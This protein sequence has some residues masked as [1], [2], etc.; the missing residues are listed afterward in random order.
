VTH[1]SASPLVQIRPG[2]F[3]LKSSTT[4][5]SAVADVPDVVDGAVCRVCEGPTPARFAVCYCCEVLVRQLQIPLVPIV[6]VTNY[7]IGDEMHRRLRGYKDAPV[8]EARHACAAQL[9]ATLDAWLAVS[10]SRLRRRFGPGWDV[11]ATV[12]SSH[13]PSGAP[14]DAVVSGVP[15]LDGLHRPVLMRGP[16][17]TGHLA[18]ARRGFALGPG[19]DRDWLRHQ[20]VLVVDDSVVTGARAQSAAAALRLGGARVAGVVAVGRVLAQEVGLHGTLR[21]PVPPSAAR[22]A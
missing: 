21:I 8:A 17:S 18:A 1:R 2:R 19:V 5:V 4:V 10:G 20:T 9:A 12:P 15:A 16:V 14:F 7:R 11:V 3:L 13:R 6:A 22:P